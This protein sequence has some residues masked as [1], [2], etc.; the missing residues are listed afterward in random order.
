MKST[1]LILAVNE[2]KLHAKVHGHQS[3]IQEIQTW[4]YPSSPINNIQGNLFPAVSLEPYK[5][6]T[7]SAVFVVSW[8]N[9]AMPCTLG[10]GMVS[11]FRLSLSAI[12]NQLSRRS[13]LIVT[14]SLAMVWAGNLNHAE[15]KANVQVGEFLASTHPLL[16][17]AN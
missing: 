12:K 2:I 5:Q 10:E 14:D 4:Q 3:Q 9:I 7:Q 6:Y 17:Q 11:Y 15:E 8:L 16:F 1:N 13:C